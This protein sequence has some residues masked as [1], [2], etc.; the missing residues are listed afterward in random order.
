MSECVHVCV[1]VLAGEHAC[2]CVCAHACVPAC[3]RLCV[4]VTDRDGGSSKGQA[5][6]HEQGDNLMSGLYVGQA[7]AAVVAAV[8]R[9][10]RLEHVCQLQ[11]VQTHHRR[12]QDGE[13][14]TGKQTNKKTDKQRDKTTKHDMSESLRGSI[15]SLL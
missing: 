11:K 7:E 14:P 8:P 3:L 10:D 5:E 13:L 6:Q 4:C 1:R 15:H 12:H 9:A 2:V